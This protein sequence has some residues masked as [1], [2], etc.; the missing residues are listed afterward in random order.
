MDTELVKRAGLVI[1]DSREACLVRDHYYLQN[2]KQSLG[3]NSAFLD[4]SRRTDHSETH[5][6]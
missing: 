2:P 5:K 4:R 1:V 3:L 6:G